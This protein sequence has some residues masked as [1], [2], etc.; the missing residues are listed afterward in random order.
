MSK[1]RKCQATNRNGEPCNAAAGENGFCFMHDANKGKER[2][3]ARKKGGLSKITPHV[4]DKSLVPKKT[5]TITEV[6]K[7]LDYTLIE[8][9]A[10]ANSIQRGRLLVS[11]AHGYI[12]AIK[13]GELEQRLEM[14]ELK[15]SQRRF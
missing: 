4:A 9:L 10:L 1:K 2:A 14:I 5:R 6:M 3:E 13:T 7:I 8:S 11:I 15:L 12:E